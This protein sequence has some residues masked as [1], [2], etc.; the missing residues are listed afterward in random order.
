MTKPRDPRM[1][2]DRTQ[3]TLRKRST[4]DLRLAPDIRTLRRHEIQ[5][6]R[7]VEA[8]R[9]QTC[10]QEN[11]VDAEFC[12]NR[13]CG[14]FLGWQSA[15]IAAPVPPGVAPSH[16]AVAPQ[17][18]A[19]R[20]PPTAQIPSAPA[21]RPRATTPGSPT[22]RVLARLETDHARVEPGSKCELN[23]VVRNGGTVVEQFVISVGGVPA[24]WVS[25]D[26]PQVN[27]DVDSEQRCLITIR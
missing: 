26:P 18:P 3:R 14:A 1:M 12:V 17:P 27:L 9:C 24:S 15:R 13:S 21:P 20:P 22:Q 6:R 2:D 4:D 19:Y 7:F 10:G 25:V 8:P 23:M 11:P 5:R 16:G